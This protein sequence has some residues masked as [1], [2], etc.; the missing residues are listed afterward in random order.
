MSG[1]SL[2]SVEKLLKLAGCKR[3]SSDA[4]RE[5][6]DYLESDGVRI[7]KLAWKFAKHAGRRTVMAEDVKLDVETMQ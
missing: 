1:V 3:I 6:K 4:C 7:G 2:R 5:L